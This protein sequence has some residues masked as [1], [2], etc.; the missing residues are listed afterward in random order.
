MKK[1]TLVCLMIFAIAKTQAQDYQI[2]FVATGAS[3]SVDSVKVENITQCTSINMSGGNILHLTATWV[4]TNEWS[5]D[6]DKMVHIYPN[7]M[8]ETCNVDFYAPAEGNIMLELFDIN[9]KIILQQQHY[10][11]KGHHAFSLSGMNSGVYFLKIES[12][13]YNYTSKIMSSNASKGVAQLKHIE[14]SANMDDSNAGKLMNLKSNK[15][16]IDMQYNLGDRLKLTGKSGNYRTVFM[17]IPNLTQS[18]TFN[19]M[20]C[21]DADSNHYTVVQIGAQIWMAEN[22]KTTKYINGDIIPIVTDGITWVNLVVGAYCNYNNSL[23]NSLTYGKLYN[24][25]AVNTAILAPNG[26]HVATDAEWTTLTN[27]LLGETGSGGKLKK[28]CTT[29]WQSPNTAAT[30]KSGFTAL[31]GGYREGSGGT[32]A[33][34]GVDGIWWSATEIPTTDGAW[35]RSVCCADSNVYR[36]SYY[37]PNGLSVRCVRD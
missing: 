22:L 24:W 3:T 1:V 16:L 17:L 6:A 12:D 4:G 28:N 32:Y 10:L 9:G 19:F 31:P 13:N 26:W 27:Y 8:T 25:Y 23:S 36:T 33:D 7:P 20:P 18:V 29:L 15:S 21:T 5:T 14:T 2:S 35:N 37:K 34:M 11:K 30:N